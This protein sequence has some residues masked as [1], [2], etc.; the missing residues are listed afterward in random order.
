M[1]RIKKEND[2]KSISLM[3]IASYKSIIAQKAWLFN[4]QLHF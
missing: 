4:W 3:E 2:G 1:Q